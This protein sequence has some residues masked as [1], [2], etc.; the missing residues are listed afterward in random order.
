MRPQEC[1]TLGLVCGGE[2]TQICR[3]PLLC[4]YVPAPRAATGHIAVPCAAVQRCLGGCEALRPSQDASMRLGSAEL[5]CGCM[6]PARPVDGGGGGGEGG[7][8]AWE[9]W[10][11]EGDIN[12]QAIVQC[13]TACKGHAL[14]TLLW[15]SDCQSAAPLRV[16]A[17]VP[18]CVRAPVRVCV[19]LRV[20]ARVHTH[21]L[22]P[23]LLNTGHSSGLIIRSPVRT[24]L[25]RHSHRTHAHA[26]TP[27]P[28]L[29]HTPTHSLAWGTRS[30]STARARARSTW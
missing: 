19:R 11:L 8:S 27:A 9:W 15:Y 6:G 29:N 25:Q 17:C 14:T 2:G 16:H 26:Q 12:L 21:V 20:C 5:D 4:L 22:R 7:I 3:P 1:N 28:P 30:R 24:P 10:D 18:P 23:G 13:A